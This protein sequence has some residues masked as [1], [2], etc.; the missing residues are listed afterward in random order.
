MKRK[1]GAAQNMK[2][3]I[4]ERR[5]RMKRRGKKGNRA[6]GK[7]GDAIRENRKGIE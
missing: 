3:K 6:I 1:K 7:R 5:K 4:V 2:G